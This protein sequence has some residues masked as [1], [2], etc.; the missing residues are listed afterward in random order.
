[1]DVDVT[2]A[3][4]MNTFCFTGYLGIVK[5]P[6]NVYLYIDCIDYIVI[7]S[8]IGEPFPIFITIVWI[9]Q[10]VR[11]RGQ[12]FVLKWEPDINPIHI[13]LYTRPSWPYTHHKK[14]QINVTFPTNMSCHNVEINI[15]LTLLFNKNIVYINLPRLVQNMRVFMP[16]IL[17]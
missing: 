11:T 6:N 10:I 9:I 5:L 13:P 12:H 4:H 14:T 16:Y 8:E 3:I 1:M 17:L 15:F 7:L 2:Y